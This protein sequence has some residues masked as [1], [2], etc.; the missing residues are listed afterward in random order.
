MTF[1]CNILLC[2]S[3]AWSLLEQCGLSPDLFLQPCLDKLVLQPCCA[4]CLLLLREPQPFPGGIVTCWR[5]LVWLKVPWLCGS[6]AVSL[7][8][9]R[10]S[11]V[12][13]PCLP[14]G[15]VTCKNESLSMLSCCR[16][17]FCLTLTSALGFGFLLLGF[18]FLP[19]VLTVVAWKIHLS[20]ARDLV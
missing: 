13:V 1:Y 18:Q 17:L 12:E 14:G 3:H 19:C 7:W 15:A 2:L 10:G 16:C 4:C 5:C 9:Y 6:G 11:V 20:V 8:G